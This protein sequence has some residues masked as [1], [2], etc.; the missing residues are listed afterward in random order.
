MKR[1]DGFTLVEMMVAL[2]VGALLM[3][4]LVALSGAMHHSFGR[5]K[6]IT[7]VQANLRFAVMRLRDDFQRSAFMYLAN[8][9]V[10]CHV[11]DYQK[12]DQVQ[13]AAGWNP[14][15]GTWNAL[16]WDDNNKILVMRGN[17]LSTRDYRIQINPANGLATVVCNNLAPYDPTV[18]DN[19]CGT[20]ETND[21]TLENADLF[22]TPA[23]QDEYKRDYASVN[24]PFADGESPGNVFRDGQV[25]RIEHSPGRYTYHQVQG[26]PTT[27]PSVTFNFTPQIAAD[28]IRCP[29]GD[30]Q[31]GCNV[32]PVI[33]VQYQLVQDPADSSNWL[34][35][36]TLWL[37]N[38]Q[39][40][41][42]DVAEFLL[43]YND[44]N[45]DAS[46]FHVEV[47][48]DRS[49]NF[50]FCKKPWLPVLDSDGD[51]LL[52]D[53]FVDIAT[54][55]TSALAAGSAVPA[56]HILRTRAVRITLR[57]RTE[58]EFPEFTIPGFSNDNADMVNFGYDLD[59]HPEN[60]LAR[61]RTHRTI[62]Q[63]RNLG[64]NL[65]S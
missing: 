22:A 41:T 23:L 27:N 34:L 55:D 36:R 48:L 32:S 28:R 52:G 51:R 9:N 26:N 8:P 19:P 57:A 54:V 46:G 14:T 49:P 35:R 29:F 38:G 24:S 21:L 10:D 40:V 65:S 31:H 5:S 61:V 1:R 20:D 33:S 11:P 45:P 59:G 60:G 15:G 58:G 4:S 30:V 47:L 44:G 17:Y 6:D 18:S 53:E 63:L 56:N 43:P 2:A 16:A 37:P 13:P 42:V 7:E 64:L 12:A 3:A 62:I 25:I 39:Q 50:G